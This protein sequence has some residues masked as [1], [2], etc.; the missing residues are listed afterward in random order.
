MP[1]SKL[2]GFRLVAPLSCGAD[3]F[4]APTWRLARVKPGHDA[5][6]ATA[7]AAAGVPFYLPRGE[8]RYQN[9]AYR[10]ITT[11][12]APLFAGYVFVGD[13]LDGEA[14]GARHV[15]RV[16]PIA[17]QSRVRAELAALDLLWRAER[18]VGEEPRF[19]PG[20]RVV[21]SHGALFGLE[22]RVIGPVGRRRLA[23]EIR[24]LGRLLSVELG[25]EDLES[26]A[27]CRAV[28]A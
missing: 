11:R 14:Y 19:E 5:K 13:R 15:L 27:R 9:E 24:T 16:E 18:P 10:A 28:V 2:I 26:L 8:W 25:P 22:G 17:D 20:E 23:V 7:M 12:K 4:D 3:P 1:E 6:Y 21:V